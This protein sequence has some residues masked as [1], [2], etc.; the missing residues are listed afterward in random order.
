MSILQKSL[1]STLL[2]LMPSAFI[3]VPTYAVSPQTAPLGTQSVNSTITSTL[4]KA[5]LNAPIANI[6]P[7]AI[8]GLY[9]VFIVGSDVPIL[10]TAT[11]DYLIQGVLKPNPS[12]Q[13]GTTKLSHPKGKAGHPVSQAHKTALLSK[14]STFKHIDST[15]AF[16]YTN[17]DGLLWGVSG[18]GGMPFLVS[19]D[20]RYFINGE[21]ATIKDG[22]Y[23]N[24]D[25]DFERTKN[26]HV[27]NT[28]FDSELAIYPAKGTQ[29]AVV[30]IATDIHCPYCQL[31]HTQIPVLN[32]QDIT[33]KVIGYPIYPKSVAPMHDIWCKANPVERA[34]L[35][36]AAMAQNYPSNH[37]KNQ[38]NPM[39]AA[40]IRA[41]SLGIFATPAIYNDSGELFYGDFSEPEFLTFLGL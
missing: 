5:G 15:A 28:F 29:K 31:F 35:L 17:I 41:H 26:R 30:Y 11:G 20:G 23:Y 24:T 14:M 7:T 10:T 8:D 18:M 32:A 25:S 27:L 39:T 19:A 16:Y 22:Q 13:S 12:F 9:E 33:V 34:A 6:V 3:G 38:K 40:Q 37:C 21:I 2:F 1:L 36:S 4:Q